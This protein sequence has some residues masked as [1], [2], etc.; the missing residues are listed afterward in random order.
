MHNTLIYSAL[1]TITSLLTA[2]CVYM[3]RDVNRYQ[4]RN[5]DKASIDLMGQAWVNNINRT[6]LGFRL[7]FIVF[8][9]IELGMTINLV[10][11]ALQ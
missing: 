5:N 1:A 2:L 6:A 10:R 8:S 7:F 4:R 11:L 3:V 9:M